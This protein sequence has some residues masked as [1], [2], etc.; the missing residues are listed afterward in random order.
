MCVYLY[1]S[2][3]ARSI[4]SQLL[5]RPPSKVVHAPPPPPSATPSFAPTPVPAFLHFD[6]ERVSAFPVKAPIY[7][8]TSC[9]LKLVRV[10]C[11][12]DVRVAVAICAILIA[13]P[14][15]TLPKICPVILLRV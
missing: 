4:N 6:R 5:D 15:E 2:A 10:F 1:F 14:Q 3:L 8:S 12:R 11:Q 7:Y 13:S 9:E